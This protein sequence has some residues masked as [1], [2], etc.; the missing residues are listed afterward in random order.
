MLRTLI[1]LGVAL[2]LAGPA[3]AEGFQRIEEREKF[4]SVIENRDLSRFGITVKV[5][6]GGDIVGRAFGQKVSGD[7]EWRQGFFCRSLFWGERNLGD[8]CQ[9]V[10]VRGESVRF[11]SDLG[12]GQFADLRIK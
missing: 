8:N 7:W 3:A 1:G 11:T 5:T 2:V 4:L 10:E 12:Q 9:K 6:G